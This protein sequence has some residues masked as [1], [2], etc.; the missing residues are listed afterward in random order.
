[1]QALSNH[2]PEYRDLEQE[3]VEAMDRYHPENLDEEDIKP[4]LS[5]LVS[6]LLPT[7]YIYTWV[8]SRS[9]YHTL[10]LLEMQASSAPGARRPN[11]VL[12]WNG[13]PSQVTLVSFIFYF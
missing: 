1:M 12:A 5:I 3:A 4:M 9:L 10:S 13:P 11:R 2:L 7:W 8:A 6:I